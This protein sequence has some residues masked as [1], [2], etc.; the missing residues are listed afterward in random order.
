MPYNV[1]AMYVNSSVFPCLFGQGVLE[2]QTEGT[3]IEQSLGHLQLGPVR[4]LHVNS[5][6]KNKNSFSHGV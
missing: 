3:H 2:A 1:A 6:A 5:S 4:A